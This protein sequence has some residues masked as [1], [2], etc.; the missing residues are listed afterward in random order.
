MTQIQAIS[1]GHVD[2]E[3]A[4][5]ANAQVAVASHLARAAVG[6]QLLASPTFHD[7]VRD[8]LFMVSKQPCIKPCSEEQSLQTKLECQAIWPQ[9][10]AFRSHLLTTAVSSLQ[11]WAPERPAGQQGAPGKELEQQDQTKTSPH[12]GYIPLLSATS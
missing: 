4:Y 9:E 10:L 2:V 11:L 5:N 8:G 7:E 6:G 1:P 3:M 12:E